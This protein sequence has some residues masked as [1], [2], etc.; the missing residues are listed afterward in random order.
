MQAGASAVEAVT[1]AGAWTTSGMWHGVADGTT[2][3]SRPFTSGSP[4]TWWYGQDGTGNYATGLRTFGDLTSPAYAIGANQ[5]LTFWSWE[6]TEN[7]PVWDTRNVYISTNGGG[8]WTLLRNLFGTENAWYQ[9][10]IDLAAYAGQSAMFRFT[11]DSIDGTGNNYKGWY[12]DE[13]TVV[14]P[15]PLAAALSVAPA[16]P[17]LGAWVQVVLTVTNV[18]G[19]NVTGVVPAIQLNAGAGLLVYEN[20]PAPAGPL[21]LAPGSSQSFTWTYSVSGSGV[22]SLTATGTGTDSGTGS[23][24]LAAGTQVFVTG[25]PSLPACG[26]PYGL[27]SNVAGT[28][29]SGYNSDGI[30]ATAAQLDTPYGL[31]ADSAGNVY[32]A[33]FFNNRVR[34]VSAATGLISTVAGTGTAGYNGEGIAATSAQ[35]NNPSGVA[36]DAAGNLYIF[37]SKNQRVR[38]VSAST[39]LISTV[40]GTG[41]ASYNGDGIAATTA[42]LNYPSFGGVDAA[43]NVYISDQYNQRVR[44]VDMTTGLIST[45]AGTGTGGYNGDGI[46]ATGA[47]INNPCVLAFDATGN[48]YI[49]DDQNY[50]IRKVSAATGLIS[51]VAGTGVAGYTGDGIAAT[52]SRINRATGITVDGNGHLYLAEMAGH[53]VRRVDAGT[54]LIGTVAGTG[55]A[56]YNGNGIAASTAQLNGPVGVALDAA[57]HLYVVNV[58]DHRVR[59]IDPVTG[60]YLAAAVSLSPSPA[61][62]GQ[63]VQVVLTVTNTGTLN[64]NGVT[65]SIQVNSGAGLVVYETGPLPAGPL[66]L[67]PGASQSFTWTYSA[68]GIGSV[69]LTATGSGTDSG[70]GSPVFSAATRALSIV[71]PAQLAASLAVAPAAVSVGQWFTVRLTITNTGGVGASGLMPFLSVNGGAALVV[72]QGTA[73]PPGPLSLAAG[74]AQTFVWTFSASGAGPVAFTAT[75]VGA[76]AVLGIPVVAAASGGATLTSLRASLAASPGSVV[77]GQWFQL[78]LTVTN[79]GGFNV[80]GVVPA[81]QINA[82]SALVVP[83]GGPVPPGPVTLVPGGAQTFLWTY[84]VSGFGTIAFTATAAGTDT[85]SGLGVSVSASATVAGALTLGEAV[86]NVPLAWTTGGNANWFP[87]TAVTY[88][89]GDAAQSGDINNS[90]SCYLQTT[91]TGPGALTFYWRVDSESGFDYLTFL[92]DGTPQAGAISGSVAWTQKTFAIPAGAHTLRWQYS[93][94]GSVTTGADAGWVDQVVFTPTVILAASLKATPGTAGAGQWV[95]LALTATN[96]GSSNVTGVVPAIQI[97]SGGSWVTYEAGPVPAGPVTLAPGASQTFAWTYSVSGTGLVWFTATAAGVDSGT[98]SPV[99]AASTVSV[100]AASGGLDA[101]DPADDASAGGSVL[102][103]ASLTQAHGLHILNG[104]LGDPNDWFRINMVAGNTY[105]FDSIGSSGGDPAADLYSDA[106]GVSLVQSDDDGGGSWQFSLDYTAAATQTYYLRV[107]GSAPTDVWSGSVNYRMTASPLAG[108]IAATPAL[109][110]VGSWTTVVMTVTNTGS[111]TDATFAAALQVTSGAG[112]VTQIGPSPS[113]GMGL[114]PGQSHAFVW[115]FSASGAG[116]VAFSVTIT[117]VELATGQPRVAVGTVSVVTAQPARM[118]SALASGPV[119]AYT[120]G[121]IT[122]SYTVTN[123]GAQTANGVGV[124]ANPAAGIGQL[125]LVAGPVPA[126]PVVLGPGAA[127]TF[128]WTYSVNGAG[129]PVLAVASNGTD[130][131]FGSP[132]ASAASLALDLRLP[133]SLSTAIA[134]APLPP[135]VGRWITV[136]VTVANPGGADAAGVTATLYTGGAGG[137]LEVM[138]GPSGPVTIPAGG[139]QTFVW[140]LSVSGAGPIVLTATATGTD[141]GLGRA[142]GTAAARG[143]DASWVVLSARAG[144]SPGSVRTRGTFGVFLTVTNSGAAAAVNVLPSLGLGDPTRAHALGA[145]T[146]PGPVTIAAGAS[147]TFVWQVRADRAGVLT[148]TP[149]VSGTD[150]GDGRPVG[151]QATVD[152]TITSLGDEPVIVFPNPAGG[153]RITVLLKLDEDAVKVDVDVFNMAPARAYQGAWAGVMAADGSLVIT[154]VRAWAPGPYL[155][156]VTAALSSG[157]IQKFAAV[158]VVVK[159]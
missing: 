97:N 140:T 81:V 67:A 104:L 131:F 41:V 38:R 130:A 79:A 39:G 2:P 100:L 21:T 139:S 156:R 133:A 72:A 122:V 134:I 147:R 50:R 146:P 22:V 124:P 153:D 27:I 80:T 26:M 132:L 56:G 24:V 159:R 119:P 152:E 108:A 37:D 154:G 8:S 6:Q 96:Y 99:S 121:W 113:F 75:A 92:I 64:A 128:A 129:T 111:W 93:K 9:V 85:G 59:R 18:G 14:V 137:P 35:L 149:S 95:T 68:S 84:S 109:L 77:T 7:S 78:A 58:G 20:G 103:P 74:G 110:P 158:K 145:P 143:V 127:Q 42:Q 29:L 44:K 10:Q 142:L 86:D 148:L 106:A 57:C 115:T 98:G 45:V 73:V 157:R 40:A 117:A 48:L 52:T 155:L 90:Q 94:D 118:Y 150:S 112:L 13:I 91:V 114:A 1:V 17:A 83:E 107:R 135:V 5:Q 120:G 71:P 54:G 51:T 60:A 49:T 46:A 126:G 61:L 47:Q 53:R 34:K 3:A 25:V 32:V 65:P 15:Q 141:A 63:W 16:A 101:Y 105:H 136:E 36:L 138:D 66:V 19:A 87:E 55:V 33:D 151:A 11:F 43:G 125:A 102:V 62:S 31:A 12:V 144:T 28:G 116:T 70:T 23:A 88:F 89:G 69:N 82:G 76:D 123:D 30:A 4:N